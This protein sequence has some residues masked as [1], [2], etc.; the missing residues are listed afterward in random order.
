MEFWLKP[1]RVKSGKL[2]FL[3]FFYTEACQTPHCVPY[4]APK[5]APPQGPESE[6]ESKSE[7][8]MPPKACWFPLTSGRLCPRRSASGRCR[9]H[10]RVVAREA[11][12][13]QPI[14]AEDALQ[15]Q[16]E[17]AEKAQR[18]ENGKKLIL[19]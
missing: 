17:T 12:T 5:I 2:Q 13:G 16:L 7:K 18:R 3:L 4:F 1:T 15:L 6:N 14:N 9:I 10:G 19:L 8:T 11:I